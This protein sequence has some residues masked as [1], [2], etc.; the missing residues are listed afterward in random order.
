MSNVRID[1]CD[2]QSHWYRE[3]RRFNPTWGAAAGWFAARDVWA[4]PCAVLLQP[5]PS[6]EYTLSVRGMEDLVYEAEL[7]RRF[8]GLHFSVPMLDELTNLCFR[9]LLERI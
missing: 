9:H 1:L 7:A 2:P 4:I 5:P 8:C 3:S 6:L